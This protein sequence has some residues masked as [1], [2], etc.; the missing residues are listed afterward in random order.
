MKRICGGGL[1][2]LV[3]LAVAG[4]R[5]ASVEI[6]KQD[7]YTEAARGGVTIV[8]RNN[9]SRPLALL[10]VTVAVG[11][12]RMQRAF[13]R[14]P[15][16]AYAPEKGEAVTV[17]AEGVED[18]AHA[19]REPL[20][21]S[22]R[23]GNSSGALLERMLM[24]GDEVKVTMDFTPYPHLGDRVT[25]TAELIHVGEVYKQQKRMAASQNVVREGPSGEKTPYIETTITT[26][27]GHMEYPLGSGPY[28]MTMEDYESNRRC[29]ADAR[30]RLDIKP[31]EFTFAEAAGKAGFVP[32]RYGYFH[33]GGMWL[34]YHGGETWF[35]SPDV[36]EHYPGSYEYMAAA[37]M[38][39]REMI[40]VEIHDE[41]AEG[42]CPLLSL[43]FEAGYAVGKTTVHAPG[44][45]RNAWHLSKDGSALL[46]HIRIK[47]GDLLRFARDLDGWGYRADGK[48]LRKK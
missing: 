6:R 13:V 14:F 36:V 11:E 2:L 16:V 8:V 28:L 33:A 24:P 41:I 46:G 47:Y 9:S 20:R 26:V 18:I 30:A 17:F 23:L 25:A 7:S 38:D 1:V 31:L 3:I 4:C 32:D 10:S 37:V 22:R 44:H 40:A 42:A 39:G 48:L 5:G 27:Y 34:F 12:L 19:A 43:L 21:Y 35:V 29:R 15:A 45:G